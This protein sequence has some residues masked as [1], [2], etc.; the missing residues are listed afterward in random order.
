MKSYEIFENKVEVLASWRIGQNVLRQ[1][2]RLLWK[3]EKSAEWS[4]PAEVHSTTKREYFK[5]ILLT[6][7]QKNTPNKDNNGLVLV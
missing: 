2:D 6:L 7:F 4:L 3:I 5:Q 1:A